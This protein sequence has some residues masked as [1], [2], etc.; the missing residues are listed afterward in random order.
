MDMKL[1]SATGQIDRRSLMPLLGGGVAFLALAG[2]A[3]A[4][5]V[6]LPKTAAEVPGP[7]SGTVMTKEYVAMVGR[8]T[9]IW[10]WA[11]VNNSNRRAA[12]AQVPE[13]G[14]LGGVLPAAPTGYVGMLYDYIDSSERFVTCPNQDTVYGAGFMAL[15]KQPVV[16]QVPDFGDRFFTYQIVDHRTDSFASIG[17]QYG[18]K[19]GHYLLVGPTWKGTVPKGI[20]AVLRS[21]TDLAAVFPR[22]FQDDTPED[23]AAIQKVLTQVMV[24]PSTIRA[25]SN[26]YVS[27]MALDKGERATAF[28]SAMSFIVSDGIQLVGIFSQNGF[29]TIKPNADVQ[30]VLANNPAKIYSSTIGDILSGV[31]EGQVASSGI[32]TRITSFAMTTE[33]PAI[34][35]Q[36][37]DIDPSALRPGMSGTATVYAPNAGPLGMLGWI[38]LKVRALMLYL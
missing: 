28:K 12:F 24:Y 2:K 32:L 36:P 18:T 14:R 16:V 4:Q 11:L 15:D 37:K 29:Q 17:K 10:G 23:K 26:G 35:N 9:Y 5:Q 34:I 19:P 25:P 33:Y 1:M 3:Q 8:L 27:T 21:S 22:V 6:P 20:K 30:F 13:P 31:G 7:V 38:L